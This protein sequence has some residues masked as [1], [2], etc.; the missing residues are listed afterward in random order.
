MSKASKICKPIDQLQPS[1]IELYPIW[2]FSLDEEGNEEQDETWVRPTYSE[3]VGLGQYSLSVA[4]DFETS[5]GKNIPGI[6]GV[7]T[8]DGVELSY[9]VLL[10]QGNYIVIP[11]PSFYD[12]ENEKLSLSLMLGEKVSDVFPLKF[13][14][15]SKIEGESVYR[16]GEFSL[17]EA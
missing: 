10:H 9:G 4:A 6:I 7:S 1:D 12:F 5:S 2:E 8:V 14:L 16:S 17:V 11:D 3:I 15:K 13:T